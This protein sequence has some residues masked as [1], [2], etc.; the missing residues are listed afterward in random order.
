MFFFHIHALVSEID[1]AING[2]AGRFDIV[3][4]VGCK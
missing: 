4:A 1:L 2:G 3:E